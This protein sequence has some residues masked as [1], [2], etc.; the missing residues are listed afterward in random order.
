MMEQS[1]I[2]I[3]A[4]FLAQA[5]RQSPPEMPPGGIVLQAGRY[6]LD[7]PYAA[8]TLEAPGPE[9]LVVNLRAFDCF[10]LVES[11]CALAL[12]VRQIFVSNQAERHRHPAGTN[13]G[14]SRDDDFR[15]RRC[16]PSTRRGQPA[17]PGVISSP[18]RSDEGIPGSLPDRSPAAIA[19][20]FAALLQRLRYRNGII[21]GYSSRRHYFSDWLAENAQSGWLQD[22]TAALGGRPSRK[23][24]DFMTQHRELYPSLRDDAVYEQLRAAELRLSALPRSILPKEEIDSWEGKITPGDILAIA[25][26]EEGLDATHAGLAIRRAG[27]LHLLHASSEAGRVIVSPENLA[28]YLQARENRAGIIVARLK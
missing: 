16:I 22:V 6:F 19:P 13:E 18:D 21:A 15:P 8:H 11:C 26:H 25:T 12:L 27:R 1:D 9:S 3:L 28:A 23:V 5:R 2:A 7:A 24:I 14:A 10:T 17:A 20:A 4:D